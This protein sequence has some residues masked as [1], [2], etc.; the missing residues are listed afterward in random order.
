MLPSSTPSLDD[1]GLKFGTDKSSALHDYLSFYEPFFDE[2]REDSIRLLEIGVFFGQSLQVWSEYFPNGMIIGADIHP[3]ARTLSVGSGVIIEIVDQSN[4]EDLVQLAVKHGPFDIVIED[5]SHLWEHQITTFKT[6][7][8]FLKSDGIYIVEDLHTNFGELGDSYRGTSRI[9]MVEY[10][11][12]LVDLRVGDDQIDIRDQEDPFLRT[13]GR[14]IHSLTFYRRACVV[15]KNYRYNAPRVDAPGT[16]SED[17]SDT[18]LS[19]LP[20]GDS[21]VSLSI[22][23]HIA[24][25][26]DRQSATGVLRVLPEDLSIQGF[27]IYCEDESV[28]PGLEYRAR[29]A[30]GTWT[31]WVSCGDFAGTMGASQNLTGFSVRLSGP[32]EDAYDMDVI[33]AFRG[34]ADM[35]MAGNGDECIPESTANQLYGMQVL[36]RIRNE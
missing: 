13:Y 3:G 5:G 18:P 32:A 24:G 17:I 16:E 31:D 33:G 27:V 12:K 28:R 29:L 4:I 19:D 11:K 7:F 2:I 25:I 1:L 15:K 10:L 8:P 26:G 36:I 9:S 14:N 35:V 22:S 30:D 23:C 34:Q 6:L 20:A 21:P